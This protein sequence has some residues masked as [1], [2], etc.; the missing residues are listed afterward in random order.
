MSLTENYDQETNL[1][2]ITIPFDQDGITEAKNFFDKL[3]REAKAKD[4][5]LISFIESLPGTFSISAKLLKEQYERVTGE[6]ITPN[7]FGKM[8]TVSVLNKTKYGIFRKPKNNGV[9]YIRGQ[10]IVADQREENNFTESVEEVKGT[11]GESSPNIPITIPL[12]LP[13]LNTTTRINIP[14]IPTPNP[15]NINTPPVPT[16]N[17]TTRITIPP[18]PIIDSKSKVITLIP[19]SDKITE[20]PIYNPIVVKEGRTIEMPYVPTTKAKTPKM[21]DPLGMMNFDRQTPRMLSLKIM[22]D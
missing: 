17:P 9:Y 15:K 14:P 6:T 22:K 12:T 2:T 8:M 10:K 13:T 1:L 20:V 7:A 4:E 21:E 3:Y 19:V 11:K 16:P 18:I 5:K